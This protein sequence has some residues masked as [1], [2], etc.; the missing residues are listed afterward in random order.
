MLVPAQTNIILVFITKQPLAIAIHSSPPKIACCPFRLAAFVASVPFIRSRRL[1]LVTIEWL[2]SELL[3]KA[4]CSSSW[5]MGLKNLNDFCFFFSHSCY[6]SCSSTFFCLFTHCMS[7]A[8]VSCD[9]LFLFETFRLLSTAFCYSSFNYKEIVVLLLF[10]VR[11]KFKASWK[12]ASDVSEIEL[13]KFHVLN[14]KFSLIGSAESWKVV[15]WKKIQLC[16]ASEFNYSPIIT[17]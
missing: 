5:L 16:D 4:E 6:H 13:K 3:Y 10:S 7:V 1:L 9:F 15:R 12:F 14:G 8:T 17:K 11:W 2:W